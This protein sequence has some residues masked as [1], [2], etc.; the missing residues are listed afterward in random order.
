MKLIEDGRLD[1]ETRA[2][3]LLNLEPPQY[4]GAAMI[5]A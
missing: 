4:P 1:L 2:F 3:S 5:L